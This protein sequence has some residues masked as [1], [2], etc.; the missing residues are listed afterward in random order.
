MAKTGVGELPGFFVDPV[1]EGPYFGVPEGS[2][3]GQ[4][5][6]TI[7][8]I[9]D[10]TYSVEESRAILSTQGEV[11]S[12]SSGDT[13]FVPDDPSFPT[14]FFRTDGVIEMALDPSGEVRLDRY[15]KQLSKWLR[16]R[17]QRLDK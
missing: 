6:R 12:Q 1:R 17:L 14:T 10:G 8:Y 16:V 4:Q 15:V 11:V 5:Q 3:M 9:S 7:R 2:A 13:K